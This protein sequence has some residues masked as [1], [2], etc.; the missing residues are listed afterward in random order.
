M[1]HIFSVPRGDVARAR[2]EHTCNFSA[3]SLLRFRTHRTLPR[4]AWRGA[5][6]V[7]VVRSPTED[8]SWSTSTPLAGHR[9]NPLCPDT[10]SVRWPSSP[11]LSLVSTL[12][13]CSLTLPSPLPP[14]AGGRPTPCRRARLRRSPRR[15]R[16]RRPRRWPRAP[17][18][19]RLCR[20]RR[21]RRGATRQ[22]E[23]RS[24][25]THR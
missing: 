23:P 9:S 3:P 25:Q 22:W 18:R 5:G 24:R 19:R 4:R 12:N 15:P 2:R 1:L 10:A 14:V 8:K 21:G 7:H 13:L 20:G 16:R 6:T 11:R 17:T